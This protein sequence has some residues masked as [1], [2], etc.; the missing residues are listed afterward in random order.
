MYI[1]KLLP[2]IMVFFLFKKKWK[3]NK[4]YK[5]GK[6][7]LSIIEKNRVDIKNNNNNNFNNNLN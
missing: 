3:L 7:V 2:T 1:M 4:I 5:I 6:H